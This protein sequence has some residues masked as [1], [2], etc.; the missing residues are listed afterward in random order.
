[1]V[2]TVIDF[3]QWITLSVTRGEQ[4]GLQ[5]FGGSYGEQGKLERNQSHQH[6]VTRRGV[7]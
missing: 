5:A 7:E 6:F 3:Q 4:R 2:M 1:M